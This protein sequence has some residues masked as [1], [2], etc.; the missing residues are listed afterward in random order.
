MDKSDILELCD[1]D[2]AEKLNNA[3]IGLKSNT[4]LIQ[5]V[6]R[7]FVSLVPQVMSRRSILSKLGPRPFGVIS[8]NCWGA[9]IYQAAGLSYT[10]PF[11]GLALAPESYLH[12]LSN[13]SLIKSPLL[14]KESSSEACV[15]R[16]RQAR[17]TFWPV[18]V[19]D[20]EVEIQFMHYRNCEEARAKWERRLQRMPVD[21]ERLFV[22]FDDR[23]GLSADQINRFVAL[24]FPNK[25][26]STGNKSWIGLQCAVYIPTR[27]GRLP[28]GLT[29]SRISPQYFDSA[30][31]IAG[32]R[33]PCSELL[34][35][36]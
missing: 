15:E 14:F 35:F 6:R 21:R 29:L 7:R 31:G 2:S 32:F 8:N 4:M 5:T 13:W 25:V 26:F 3:M 34:S 11:V 12:L 24:D 20:G 36:V 30:A 9:H 1:C 22:K 19:L 33:Q 28:D 17:G 23:D 16:I 18:G 27:T 10:T